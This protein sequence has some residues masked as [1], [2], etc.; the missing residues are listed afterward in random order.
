MLERKNFE[1]FLGK[2]VEVFLMPDTPRTSGTLVR[3]EDD[4]IVIGDEVWAYPAVLGIRPLKKSRQP[5]RV[6]QAAVKQQEVV[7]RTEPVSTPSETDESPENES[8]SHDPENDPPPAKPKPKIDLSTHEFEGTLVSFYYDRGLWGFIDSEE[9]K[10]YNI[11]LRD[12]EKIFVHMNQISDEALKN[13]LINDRNPSPMIEVFFKIGE[14]KHGAVADD[15]RA[16]EKIKLTKLPDDVLKVDMASALYE[17]GEIEFF[18]RYEEIPHG[19]IRVKGNKLYRFEESDVVDP[20][21]AVF[22]ECSP[23]AEGQK[24]RFVQKAGKRG[25]T[26]ATNVA[27]AGPFPEEKVRDWEKSGLIQK[28]KERMGIK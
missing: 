14:N 16:K 18:R 24:V 7:V 5:Q 8:E 10:K 23:S 21:L 6:K 27:A 28:A 9:V 20:V 17:E 13:K 2:Q 12:G 15:V 19:E 11:P 26:V 1:S 4:H 22:L 3:C 25:K